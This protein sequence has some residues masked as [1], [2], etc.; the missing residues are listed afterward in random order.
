VLLEAR[1]ALP[2][3][4]TPA[5]VPPVATCSV[6]IMAFNEEAN[7]GR[8]L[9]ALGRQRLEGFRIDEIIVVASGCTDATERI[10]REHALRDDRIRLVSQRRREGKAAAVNLFLAQASG[11]LLVLESADTLPLPDT[12]QRLLTPFADPAVGMTGARPRPVD[13]MNT[14]MGYA[15]HFLW[16]MH[17]TLALDA[18]K[19]GEMVA[20]RRGLAPIPEDTAVDEAAIEVQV[21]RSGRRI[22]YAHSAVVRNKGPETVRDYLVQRRRIV[23]GHSHLRRTQSHVVTSARARLVLRAFAGKLWGHVRLTSRLLARRRFAYALRYARYHVIRTTYA[24]GAVGLEAVG[25]TL[26]GWDFYVRRR[27]PYVWE[28]ARSTKRL[29]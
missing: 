21:S 27:N 10:V 23:A 8:L 17:H 4:A 26:G 28:I 11:D 9:S 20:F 6:G 18:P 3:T 22:E 29:P 14:F 1:S 19:L 7:V 2:M 12:V 15:S 24:V 25:W 13:R 5:T 16:W